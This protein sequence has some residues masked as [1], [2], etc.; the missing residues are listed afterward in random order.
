MSQGTVTAHTTIIKKPPSFLISPLH[1]INSK[2]SF[3]WT[4]HSAFYL[5]ITLYKQSKVYI[6]TNEAEKTH[7]YF[8]LVDFPM[9]IPKKT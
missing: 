6:L 2:I 8:L 1:F 7:E 3:N 5:L 4:V 9:K